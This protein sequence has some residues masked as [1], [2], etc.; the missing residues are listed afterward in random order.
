MANI[1]EQRAAIKFCFLLG[2]SALARLTRCLQL[3]KRARLKHEP[4][5]SCGV[6]ALNAARRI[7]RKRPVRLNIGR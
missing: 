7:A 1:L 5:C 4:E 2:H 6:R 3:I